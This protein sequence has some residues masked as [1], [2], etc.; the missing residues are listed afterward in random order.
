MVAVLEE[1]AVAVGLH[2][3]D[4][5]PESPW[6]RFQWLLGEKAHCCALSQQIRVSW[7]HKQTRPTGS[8]QRQMHRQKEVNINVVSC[9]DVEMRWS[10]GSAG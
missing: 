2:F 5:A 8:G 4:N 7:T 10:Q 1:V 3:I 6:P 9:S